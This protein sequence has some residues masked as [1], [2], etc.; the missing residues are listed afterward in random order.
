MF[1]LDP[2]LRLRLAAGALFF[3]IPLV[4][5]EVMIATRAP[6][7]RLPYRSM[8]YWALA[9]LLITI[10]LAIW[11]MAGRR[12]VLPLLKVLLGTW[13]MVGLLLA[14]RMGSPSMGFFTLFLLAL[15]VIES[16]WVTVE[17]GRSFLDP[18]M[19]WYQGLPK[20]IPG[21]KCQIQVGNTEPLQL[22]VSRIDQDGAFVF[23]PYHQNIPAMMP[24]GSPLV[25]L[26]KKKDLEMVF[27]FRNRE[28]MCKGVPISNV[29]KGMGAGFQ[30]K[31]GSPDVRKEIGDFVEALRG[32]GY[33]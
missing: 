10:P 19:A 9:F 25:P 21:L 22:D 1:I 23:L 20:P 16:Q 24:L 7:W 12:W 30:F 32:E 18:Q 4:I 27:Q 33:V 6:W 3:S 14:I 17:M 8:A 5:C 13:V 26:L 29:D 31:N 15:S 2:P 11:V 28:L